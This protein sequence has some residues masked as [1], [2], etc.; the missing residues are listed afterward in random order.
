MCIKNDRIIEV[1]FILEGCWPLQ[2]RF[3]ATLQNPIWDKNI[4][5]KIPFITLPGPIPSLSFH[6]QH[7]IWIYVYPLCL[8][9]NILTTYNRKPAN[10]RSFVC[11]LKYT[12]MMNYTFI[13]Q[14]A[15]LINTDSMIYQTDV[16]LIWYFQS[17]PF[18]Y[19]NLYYKCTTMY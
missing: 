6:R 2:E 9:F 17:F 12:Q 4:T 11:F 14:L 10:N 1:D 15:F 19:T 8:Y 5:L 18:L 3:P 16:S 13:L 7:Q